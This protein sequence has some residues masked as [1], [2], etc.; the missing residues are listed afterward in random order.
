MRQQARTPAAPLE[1]RLARWRTSLA[2]IGMGL[3][4][5][6]VSAQTTPIQGTGQAYVDKVIEGLPDLDGGI[7]LKSSEY[8]EAGW[9][10]SWRVDY[11]L[12]RQTGGGDTTARALGLGGFVD[13][14][15]YG[16]LSINANLVQQSSNAA[17]NQARSSGSTWRI[18]QRALPLD[19]GW[20]ANHNA[21]DINTVSTRLARGTG[22]VSVPATPIRGVGGQWYLND[23]IDLNAAAGRTGLFNG[24]DVTGFE[25]SG[26]SISSAGAQFRLPF[27]D[28]TGAGG[29]SDAAFQLIDG[30]SISD[31]AGTGN[32]QNTRAYFAAASWEGT[33]PWAS[34]LATGYGLAQRTRRRPAPASQHGAKRGHA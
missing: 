15:N 2:G 33:A 30:K 28:E 32:A 22:R 8:N 16:A 11:S 12:F 26:G 34:G 13:T 17:G 19:G 20:F 25:T 5:A 14:P 29:R 31:G 4:A 6:T 24:L 27:G 21:G 10:R 23:A 18:D 7:Q 1:L 9:P 3:A